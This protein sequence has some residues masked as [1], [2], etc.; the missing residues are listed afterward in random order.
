MFGANGDQR[1]GRSIYPLAY[2][3]QM[4]EHIFT[5]CGFFGHCGQ[6]HYDS[7]IDPKR[8]SRGS[9]AELLAS[10]ARGNI[11]LEGLVV[12]LHMLVPMFR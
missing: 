2:S 11:L 6:Y 7:A 9:E 1:L 3:V 8:Y 5:C 4:S 10:E 12:K